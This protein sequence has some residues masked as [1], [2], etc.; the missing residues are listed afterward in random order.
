MSKCEVCKINEAEVHFKRKVKGQEIEY[1]RCKRCA[2]VDDMV[3]PI[4]PQVLEQRKKEA[5]KTLPEYFSKLEE[6]GDKEIILEMKGGGEYRGILKGWNEM[7]IYIEEN[8]ETK[9]VWQSEVDSIFVKND[10]PEF[11]EK[12]V[13]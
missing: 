8:K 9:M 3:V 4:D 2:Y 11:E 13:N 7:A 12:E 1:H 5:I 10:E 6:L